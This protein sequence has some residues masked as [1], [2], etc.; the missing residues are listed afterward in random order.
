MARDQAATALANW[1]EL[2]E[3]AQ[4]IAEQWPVKRRGFHH[5][6]FPQWRVSVTVALMEVEAALDSWTGQADGVFLDGFSPAL[7][8]DMWSSAVFQRIAAR[9]RPGARLATFTVAGH[10]RRG[11]Q[12][13]GFGVAKC[14][15]FGRKR[16]RLEAVFDGETTQRQ[17]PQRIAIAG[18]GIAGACLAWQ[19]RLFGVQADIYDPAP[20][21]GASGNPA[22]LVT[23]RL[24]AGDNTIS[25]LFS[26]AFAYATAFYRRV[27]PEAVIGEGVWQ[28]ALDSR[29]LARFERISQQAGFVAGDLAL[30]A[31]GD[32]VTYPGLH[33]KPALYISPADLLDRLLAGQ[34]VIRQSIPENLSGYDAVVL[35]C[36]DGILDRAIGLPLRPVR[37]QIEIA[38]EVTCDRALACGGYAVPA[39]AGLLFGATHDR[40][41]RGR[42]VRQV[43]RE[44][45][46]ANLAKVMPHQAETLVG[47]LMSRASVRVTTRDQLPVA[48]EVSPGLYVLTGL[49]SRGFCLA[50]LLAKAILADMTGLAPPLSAATH[51]LLRPTR[52]ARD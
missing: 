9:V 33:L 51:R 11:L 44:A 12:D 10:V 20:G 21:S 3:F 45:N 42:D 43:S 14:P 15:G 48:G 16:E 19:A 23:P 13:A 34:A 39:R 2:A 22:A 6:D 41:D 50:P 7:N 32:V 25:A 17:R 18:A 35:A 38:A 52:F 30:F 29:D 8:P 4:A 24:D 46:L 40:D 27:A 36:G 31:P 37:G 5:M 26:D 49:G 1:P 47:G 28:C